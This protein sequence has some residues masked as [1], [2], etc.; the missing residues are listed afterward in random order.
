[1]YEAQAVYDLAR[2]NT[3][4]AEDALASAY[5]ALEAITGQPHPNIDVLS[6]EFPVVEAEGSMDNWVNE[7]LNNNPQLLAAR[8]SVEAQS[9]IAKARSSDRWPTVTLQGGYSNSETNSGQG[10]DGSQ[11]AVGA[12]EGVSVALS[13]SIPLYT[14]HALTARRQQA[15]Y[16]LVAQQEQANLIRR[17]TTQD[18]RNAYRR[19][20]TDA[21]VIAQR[22]QAII[23]AEAAL[24]AI[25]AGYEV[26]TR[27][28]VDVLQARQLL[29]GA[30]RDFANARYNYV[31]DTLE[32][33]RVAGVLTPQDIIDLNEWL[34]AEA[35]TAQ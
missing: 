2:N 15:E 14:G 9:Q 1:M 26:G 13:V 31:I 11:R 35:A 12:I 19:V 3:I 16:D 10:T 22:Q 34:E 24:N 23:S 6:E 33:K 8:Y 25:E 32:L 21:L 29:F 17:T 7:A 28:I 30:L 27:N 18:I 20:N 5:E 4:L